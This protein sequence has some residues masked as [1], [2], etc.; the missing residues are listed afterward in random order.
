MQIS[1]S[2]QQEGNKDPELGP[3][4]PRSCK[5][6]PL[7]C[8]IL[9]LGFHVAFL[10]ERLGCRLFGV[11][12]LTVD[13]D[14]IVCVIHIFLAFIYIAFIFTSTCLIIRIYPHTFSSTCMNSERTQAST[15]TFL[16]FTFVCLSVFCFCENR[17]REVLPW[18][19]HSNRL[20]ECVLSLWST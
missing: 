7:L 10:C 16:I 2:H 11:F 5:R 19:S 6:L 4:G 20:L 3:W 1:T 13:E 18:I 9:L 15:H 12:L 17:S 8:C 14:G